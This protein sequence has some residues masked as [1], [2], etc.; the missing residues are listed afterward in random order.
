MS[1]NEVSAPYVRD[2]D[3][4]LEETL[5]QV[6][7]P[8]KE[9]ISAMRYSA[10][11]GG[12][13]IRGS[14]LLETYK[15]FSGGDYRAA[16][17][18]ACGLEMIHAY[19]LVHDDLPC[20]DDDD[21]RRGKPSCHKAFGEA[22]ALL[23]GDA[24][25]NTAFEV[26][27]RCETVSPDRTLKVIACISQRS[28]VF[29][30][31][32]GQVIDLSMEGEKPPPQIHSR[33]VALKTG[34]L[35]EGACMAG[36]LL[37]GASEEKVELLRSFGNEYGMCFQLTDDLLDVYGDEAKLG[38]TVGKD[39]AADKATFA[40]MLGVEEC[41]KKQKQSV[42]AMQGLLNRLPESPLLRSFVEN[43]AGREF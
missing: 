34:A 20:M 19:S 26:M 29:G 32:G 37:A 41:K 35:F 36:G 43:A 9:I 15:M 30:M 21:M 38:K 6:E 28:G 27:S 12:K 31:I 24:L 25:L 5:R 3:V 42:N 39:A 16:L 13:R 14:M 2:I 7:C 23:C 33:M 8:Q 1:S 10:L 4:M 40:S 17:P 22:T 18:F 11:G